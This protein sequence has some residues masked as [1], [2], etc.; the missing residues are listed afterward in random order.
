MGGFGQKGGPPQSKSGIPLKRPLD[1]PDFGGPAKQPHLG[2]ADGGAGPP[3]GLPPG[4]AGSGAA[5][6]NLGALLAGGPGGLG[7]GPLG[8]G[9][10][11]GPLGP[12][13][14][15]GAGGPGGGLGGLDSPAAALAAAGPAGLAAA[16]AAA[17]TAGAALGGPAIP[18]PD[19]KQMLHIDIPQAKVG[20]VVGSQGATINSIK[21]ISGA[22]CV[23]SPTSSKPG[24]AAVTISGGAAEVEKCRGLVAALVVDG[25]GGLPGGLPGFSGLLAKLGSGPGALGGPGGPPPAALAALAGSLGLPPGVGSAGSLASLAALAASQSSGSGGVGGAG[26]LDLSKLGSLLA[27]ISGGPGAAGAASYYQQ[28]MTA[29]LQAAGSGGPGAAPTLPEPPV[30]KVPKPQAFDREALARLAKQA[31][32]D[33]AKEAAATPAVPQAPP[34]VVGLPGL[35]DPSTAAAATALGLP[36]LGS[37]EANGRLAAP[38]LPAGAGAAL[39]Q[40]PPPSAVAPA[41]VEAPAPP[42]APPPVQPEPQLPRK[43]PSGGGASASNAAPS[44]AQAALSLAGFTMAASSSQSRSSQKDSSSVLGI[45]AMAQANIAS[46]RAGG[47]RG[48]PPTA[49][50]TQGD[51]AAGG[52]T[53]GVTTAPS[54]ASALEAITAKLQAAGTASSESRKSLGK[55]VLQLLPKLDPSRIAELAVR[56]H[57]VEAMRTEDLLSDM[58]QALVTGIPRFGSAHLTR[59]TGTLATWALETSDIGGSGAAE[60]IR[61][62]EAAR[63]FFN[64]VSAEVSL[65]LMDVAP[66]DL[67][68]MALSLASVGLGGV[69]LF[70]SLARAAVARSDRFQPGELVALVGVFDKSGFFQQALFE[71]L[72]RCMRVN[73]KD[74]QARD[75]MKGLQ[76]LA[77]CG[78]R[79]E[80]LGQAMGEH[81]PKKAQLGGL[82]AEEF[83]SLAWTFCALDLHHD[84]FFRAVF[85]ALED[86]AVVSGETLCQLYEIH[87]SL[88]AFH[89]GSY[90][91]YELEDDTAKSLCEHYKKQ[92]SSGCRA[93]KLERTSERLHSDVSDHLREVLECSISMQHS[94][95]LGFTVDVVATKK[96]NSTPLIYLDID[97]PHTIVRSLDPT[98]GRVHRVRADALLRRRVIQKNGFRIA[99]FTEDDWRGMDGSREK[100]EF[101][102]VMLRNAGVSEER[103]I[104]ESSRR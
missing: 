103:L 88:K 29:A 49:S 80:E 39:L 37:V 102:R 83:C 11:S 8:P 66:G 6:G 45:L 23:V 10:P 19:G 33:A 25:P 81:V 61:L 56:L 59:L 53:P 67:S 64:T 36:P 104:S 51:G 27:G 22:S 2:Q 1:S 78:V 92:R 4:A 72:V 99:S 79:D 95:P 21:A 42:A 65:R 94:M 87:L 47:A 96:R 38:P 24:M 89:H 28:L 7:G 62:S 73:V 43:P 101:L 13:M 46:Q 12:G 77:T 15:P 68:R 97:G 76:Y 14:P 98:D 52:T 55:E 3:G 9:L 54:S 74:M 35:P 90:A 30:E 18:G 26:S 31:Q 16:L 93:V 50:A 91:A 63:A 34:P 57:A 44:S 85:R 71:A 58:C 48:Q 40:T 60:K 100:R 5:L 20:A 75:L 86:A 84:K 32:E 82:N 41:P 70:S 69:R 17:G